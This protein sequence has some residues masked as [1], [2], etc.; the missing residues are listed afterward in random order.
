MAFQLTTT[1]SVL[2][3]FE[4]AATRAVGQDQMTGIWI[5]FVVVLFFIAMAIGCFGDDGEKNDC[6]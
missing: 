1:I 3:F 2:K 5:H 6:L 4:K